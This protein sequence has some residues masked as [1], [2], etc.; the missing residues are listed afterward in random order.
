MCEGVLVT[1]LT[2]LYG[3][4]SHISEHARSSYVVCNPSMACSCDKCE[5]GEVDTKDLVR[6]CVHC[7]AVW[8]NITIDTCPT[9]GLK[10]L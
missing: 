6:W 3:K 2:P 9:C 10:D 1:M 8:E 4:I 5:A 7:W